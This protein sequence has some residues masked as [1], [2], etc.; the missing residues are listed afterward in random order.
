LTE[1][2]GARLDEDCASSVDTTDD[3]NL[4]GTSNDDT[5][6]GIVADG[7]DADGVEADHVEDVASNGAD[8]GIA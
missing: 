3:T 2:I 6:A 8:A 5:R 7:V 4:E 1:G